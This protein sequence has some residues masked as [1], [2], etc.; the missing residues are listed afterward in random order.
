[1][2][3][4]YSELFSYWIGAV[5]LLL[6][7]TLAGVAGGRAWFLG[8]AAAAGLALLLGLN[9]ANP[10]AI[11]ARDQLAG[12]HRVEREDPRYLSQLS[13]DATPTLVA[14][15]DQLDPA[16]RSYLVDHVCAAHA[17]GTRH[18]GW[19]AWNL[20]ADRARHA[21]AGVCPG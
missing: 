6:G 16:S 21:A 9:L 11:V 2:L 19:A 10:E 18:R 14:G 4:L 8:A 20:G 7:A 15:L 1:M 5:F 3:R 13:A 12:G 17:S